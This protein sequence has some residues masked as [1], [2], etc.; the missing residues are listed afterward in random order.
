MAAAHSMR[1]IRKKCYS[2][3]R[4]VRGT[5]LLIRLLDL[6]NFFGDKTD[7]AVKGQLYREPASGRRPVN[8]SRFAQ[9][10]KARPHNNLLSRSVQP[11]P[12]R[13]RMTS[14]L[15][16]VR[17]LPQPGV[18][19]NKVPD[20]FGYWYAID[21]AAGLNIF[22]DLVGNILDPVL[23][24]VEGHDANGGVELAG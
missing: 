17:R 14:D 20:V 3:E 21:I 10:R 23:K 6:D 9:T 18:A 24:C 8:E 13:N 5:R 12:F 4:P 7:S 22:G 1:M 2:D 11:H 16:S 15:T 19:C